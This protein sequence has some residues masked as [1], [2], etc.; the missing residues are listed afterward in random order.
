MIIDLWQIVERD[1]RFELWGTVPQWLQFVATAAALWWAVYLYRQSLRDKKSAQAKLVYAVPNGDAMKMEAGYSYNIETD[2]INTEAYPP[3][4]RQGAQF[5][6]DEDALLCW[7]T[8]KNDSAEV[9]NSLSV[10]VWA[11]SGK[12][13]G[14]PKRTSR[15]RSEDLE[16]LAPGES[17][18]LGIAMPYED[19]DEETLELRTFVKFTDFNGRRWRRD[20]LGPL[21]WSSQHASKSRLLRPSLWV[22]DDDD[23]AW[24][25]AKI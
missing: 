1:D 5:V 3:L 25:E 14:I 10:A 8:L 21:Y 2:R 24:F 20:I 11:S 19:F 17:I 13:H 9:M 23:E 18:E 4:R 22:L 6:S 7:I 15:G 12:V 16:Y